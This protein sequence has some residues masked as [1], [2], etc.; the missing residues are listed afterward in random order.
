MNTAASHAGMYQRSGKEWEREATPWNAST[1]E[2]GKWNG[3]S[4]F[5]IPGRT[6]GPKAP[7]AAAGR[8]G[9]INRPV[10]PGEAVGEI[11]FFPFH[12][13]RPPEY[14]GEETSLSTPH[15]GAL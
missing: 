2:K 6:P 9:A 1:A 14:I 7:P 12:C 8:N 5:P 15:D 4:P 3:F 13:S 11:S 10:P